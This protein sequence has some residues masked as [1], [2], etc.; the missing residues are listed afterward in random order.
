MSQYRKV[1]LALMGAL[2]LVTVIAWM[3]TA[4]GF[5]YEDMSHFHPL[6]HSDTNQNVIVMND[7]S[8]DMLCGP[9]PCGP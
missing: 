8:T 5:T 1:G 4:A 3:A 9:S 7:G 6:R 2:V